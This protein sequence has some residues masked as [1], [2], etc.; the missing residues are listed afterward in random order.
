MSENL[1][2][3]EAESE[4]ESVI[5]RHGFTALPICPF[6]IAESAD[7]IVQPKDSDEPGVSGFLMRVGSVFGI[8]YARHIA[9]EGFIRFTIAHE[10]GHYFLPGHPEQLFPNGDGLHRSRSGFISHKRL[11]RQA[12]QFAAALLM[13]E[14]LFTKAIDKAGQG[15]DAIQSLAA[16]C[17]TSITAT[18]IR[19]AR[20]TDDPVAVIVSNRDRVEYCFLSERLKEVNGLEWLKKGDPIAA[21]PQPQALMRIPST[22]AKPGRTTGAARLTTGSTAHRRST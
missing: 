2:L 16:L 20:Y 10:L 22:S 3:L 1:D 9:N 21:R 6:A 15:F 13:P 14:K 18:A 17:K 5:S 11:E 8:L 4:A 12:D 19:F 7:I